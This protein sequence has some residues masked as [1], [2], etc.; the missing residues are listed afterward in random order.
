MRETPKQ[1]VNGCE[2]E[3]SKLKEMDACAQ[4][5]AYLEKQSSYQEAWEN[6]T[7]GDWMLWLLGKVLDEG[8][9]VEFR[10]LTLAKARC[11]KLVIDLICDDYSKKAVEVAEKFGLGEATREE[12]DSAAADAYAYAGLNTDLTIASTF[13]LTSALASA[14]TSSLASTFPSTSD[15]MFIYP[16]AAA[17]VAASVA[18]SA[19]ASA[20]VDNAFDATHTPNFYAYRSL[21]YKI[22]IK[23]LL[24][25]AEIVREIYSEPPTL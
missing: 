21:A 23:V 25:C 19:A 12:L 10:R 15:S 20:A 8:N 22:K 1:Q 11:S 9:E 6:C 16:S 14:S 24:D 18:A 3:I 7:R 17:S 5:L 2:R 13:A 4:A